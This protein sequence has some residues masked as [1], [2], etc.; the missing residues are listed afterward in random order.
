MTIPAAP[1]TSESGR[2]GFAR[3]GGGVRCLFVCVCVVCVCEPLLV[4]T[5]CAESAR[6]AAPRCPPCSLRQRCVRGD[7]V[8]ARAGSEHGQARRGRGPIASSDSCCRPAQRSCAVRRRSTGPAPCGAAGRAAGAVGAR[9]RTGQEV[10][11]TAAPSRGDPLSP[12]AAVRPRAGA[13][14]ARSRRE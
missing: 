10:V 14:E 5:P 2:S 3:S 4:A 7:S 13:R 8:L 1:R 9:P 11:A 12:S 6:R